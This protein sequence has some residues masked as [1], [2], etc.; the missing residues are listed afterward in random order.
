MK[1][2]ESVRAYLTAKE[3]SVDVM[4]PNVGL[5]VVFEY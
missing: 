2:L 5:L 4:Y 3:V 1:K